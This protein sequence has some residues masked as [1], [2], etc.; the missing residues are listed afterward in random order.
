M[1]KV[2]FNFVVISRRLFFLFSQADAGARNVTL[3]LERVCEFNS[4]LGG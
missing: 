4:S 1:D 2:K 3:T